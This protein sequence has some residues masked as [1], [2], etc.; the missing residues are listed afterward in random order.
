MKR[1]GALGRLQDL[2]SSKRA[3]GT[4]VEIEDIRLLELP[5]EGDVEQALTP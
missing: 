3:A 5:E 2:I 4:D 1:Q